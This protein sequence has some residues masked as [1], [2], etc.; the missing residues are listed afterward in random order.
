MFIPPVFDGTVKLFAP[1]SCPA[2]LGRGFLDLREGLYANSVIVRDSK[3]LVRLDARH[4]FLTGNQM[5]WID[6]T[7]HRM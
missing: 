4:Q 5:L 7:V 2:D 3:Q 1:P 6:E